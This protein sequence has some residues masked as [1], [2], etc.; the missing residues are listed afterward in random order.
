M[1]KLIR[2]TSVEQLYNRI[3]WDWEWY[4]LDGELKE[5]D[6]EKINSYPREIVLIVKNTKGLNPDLVKKLN[7]NHVQFSVVG[8]LNYFEKKKFHTGSYIERTLID[9]IAL[10]KII[11][12]FEKIES[13]IRYSWTETQKCMYIYKTLVECISYNDNLNQDSISYNY[14]NKAENEYYKD[15]TRSLYGVLYGKLVCSGFAI[16][17]KEALNRIGI[18]CCY[19]NKQSHHS[20]NLAELDGKIRGLELTWDCSNKGKDNLCLFRYFGLESDFYGNKHHD[21][22]N[23]PEEKKYKLTPFTVDDI[24][25]NLKVIVCGTNILSQKFN[26]ILDDKGN[27][28]YYIQVEAGSINTYMIYIDHKLIPVYTD[29]EPQYLSKEK[30]MDAVNT[31][32]NCILPLKNKSSNKYQNYNRKDNS[33]FIITKTNVLK[34]NINEHFY[35]DVLNTK[36]GLKLRRGVIL[37]EMDLSIDYD[38]SI[39]D[40]IAN[41]LLG[42]DRLK[43]KIL[44]YNGYVGYIGKNGMMLYDREFETKELHISR[45][46]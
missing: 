16:V 36:E 35:Y 46:K 15:V 5:K 1:A 10:S 13:K 40:I 31:N 8:G 2:C 14:Y 24:V 43:R 23:E 20:W 17:L 6:I 7:S 26:E 29:L 19:Q 37:S 12:F 41:E 44:Y 42:N 28:I 39:R 25:K 21:I 27:K 38:K 4:Y 30:I 34:N 9:P 22:S 33:S 18:K 45:R 3:G 32:N 11:E